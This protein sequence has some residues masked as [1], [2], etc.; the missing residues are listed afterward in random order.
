[1]TDAEKPTSTQ[2]QL[3]AL[4]AALDAVNGA[5]REVVYNPQAFSAIVGHYCEEAADRGE[6][7][8]RLRAALDLEPVRFALRLARRQPWT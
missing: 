4:E 2:A 6:C 3:D 1:V 8:E 5:W 7:I